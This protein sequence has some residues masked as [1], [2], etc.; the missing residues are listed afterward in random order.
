MIDIVLVLEWVLLITVVI[1]NICLFFK[2]WRMCNDVRDLKRHFIGINPSDIEISHE[3]SS[4]DEFRLRSDMIAEL[5]YIKMQ[6][7]GDL[8]SAEIR[9]CDPD[10]ETISIIERYKSIYR[11]AGIAFPSD[12][13]NVKSYE[14]VISL[15]GD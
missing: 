8:S 11:S 6:V 10:H 5:S 12:F 14:D 4:I 15:L 3:I 7:N 9:F 1:L 2:L 13:D